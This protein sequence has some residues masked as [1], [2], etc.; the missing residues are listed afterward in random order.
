VVIFKNVAATHTD[1]ALF[2]LV[3]VT[4]GVALRWN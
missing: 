1:L 4:V 2:A 3:G